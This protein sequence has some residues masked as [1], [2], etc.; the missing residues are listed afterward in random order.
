[1]KRKVLFVNLLA[2]T[3]LMFFQKEAKAQWYC[4]PSSDASY[5][6]ISKFTFDTYS[7]TSKGTSGGYDSSTMTSGTPVDTIYPGKSYSLKING[8]YAYGMYFAAWIDLNNNKN[9]NDAGEYIDSSS[10][11]V[12]SFS[13]TVNIPKTVPPGMARIRVR[14]F[15]WSSVGYYGGACATPYYNYGETEDYNVYIK[16]ISKN[17]A[18]VTRILSPGASPCGDSNSKITVVVGNF[19]TNSIS[20]IPVIMEITPKGGKKTTISDTIRKT[21]NVGQTDTFTFAS[22]YNTFGG[23]QYSMVTYTK[24]P[25]DTFTYNDTSTYV[26]GIYSGVETPITKGSSLCK[27]GKVKLYNSNNYLGYNTFWFNSRTSQIPIA[28]PANDTFYTPVLSTTTTYYAEF[29][30][31]YVYDNLGAP[32]NKIGGGTLPYTTFTNGEIFDAISD[33]TLDS[34]TF[35]SNSSGKVYLNLVDANNNTLKTAIFSVSSSGMH[36]VGVNMLIPKGTN[37]TL[38]ANNSTVTGLYRNSSGAKGYYPSTASG[39]VNIHGNTVGDTARWYFFYNWTVTGSGC[40]SKRDSFTVN[41]GGPVAVLNQGTPFKGVFSSGTVSAPDSVGETDTVRYI[42]SPPSGLTNADYGKKWTIT[43]VTFATASGTSTI[44]TAF[45]YP[46]SS[47]SGT[48]TFYPSASLSDSTFLLTYKINTLGCDTVMSRYMYVI[49]KPTAGFSVSGSCSGAAVTFTNT[50]KGTG[51]LS[52]LWDFGDGSSSTTTNPIHAYAK[53]GYYTVKLKIT[54][55]KGS[56]DSISHTIFQYEHPNVN[57]GVANTCL[58]QNTNFTDSSSISSGSI[59]NKTF[60][61]GDGSTVDSASNPSHTYTSENVY[62]VI[63]TERSDKGCVSSFSKDITIHVPPVPAF[64][65]NIVCQG[66]STIFTNSTKDNA[67]S[68]VL[69][70]WNFGDGSISTDA[71]PTHSY[72]GGG[73]FT[74]WLLATNAYGCTDSISGSVVVHAKPATK[75]G[76]ENTCVEEATTFTDSS[77][78]SSGSITKSEWDFGDST[79]TYSSNPSHKYLAAGTYIVSLSQVSDQGCNSLLSKQV[80]IGSQPD[81]NFNYFASDTG[82]VFIPV[83]SSNSSYNWSF[84]DST[85]STS[86]APFHK[87]KKDSSYKVTLMV[88]NGNG[89]CSMNSYS[90]SVSTTGTGIDNAI[91]N[92]IHLQI[93]PNPFNDIVRFTYSLDHAYRVS[94]SVYDLTGRIVASNLVNAVQGAGEYNLTLNANDYK[95]N[96]GVYLIKIQVGNSMIAERLVLIK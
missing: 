61:F 68:S 83:S 87:Y 21:L 84:G 18:G 39:V 73:P 26:A 72:T 70:L 15:N 41:I 93:F 28:T 7:H 90:V 64:T 27:P 45:R 60:D 52:S 40:Y 51:S 5:G 31:A 81:A 34:V 11:Q 74:T 58:G 14:A 48:F 24:Y 75:F 57:F 86:I 67:L 56:A 92:S 32:S 88:N 55:S 33:F 12:K 44:D 8:S 66:T 69:Y 79:F 6:Y 85:T 65:T 76:V 17:D 22:T 63:L 36:R 16:S 47:S 1:M 2:L 4:E 62:T 19:G 20:N 43:N 49:A 53:G 91:A 54:A 13:T 78:I 89:P 37:Y 80:I 59:A 10:S 35:Y 96:A 82:I 42:L 25:K 77:S 30:T 3:F 94:A 50:S 9:F 29:S 95:M 23:S 71:S 38:D 46:T